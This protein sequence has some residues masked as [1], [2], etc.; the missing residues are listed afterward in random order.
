MVWCLCS[1]S[2]L[3][4]MGMVGKNIGAVV[5]LMVAI[6]MSHSIRCLTAQTLLFS[7]AKIVDSYHEILPVGEC[8]GSSLNVLTQ[9]LSWTT[10]F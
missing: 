3:S 7:K 4:F 8:L 2:D 5:E 10:P 9:A 6:S 1:S